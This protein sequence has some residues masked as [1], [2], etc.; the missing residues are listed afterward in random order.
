MF[1]EINEERYWREKRD[2]A[3]TQKLKKLRFRRRQKAALDFEERMFDENKSCRVLFLSIG[4]KPEY[5]DDIALPMMQRYLWRFIRRMREASPR[6]E[7]LYGVLGLQWHLEE[8]G[9]GGGFHA[10][11][12]IFYEPDRSGDVRVCRELGEFWRDEVARGWGGYHNS[13]ADKHRFRSRWGI[14][15]G[16][17]GRNHYEM[18]EALRKL[19]GLYMCKTIQEPLA[20][21]DDDKMWGKVRFARSFR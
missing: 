9:R 7:L 18:R 20:R 8:G 10:H 12:V 19:M 5:R 6:N 1:D 2:S 16:L 14:G 3:D 15:V 17:I 21:D 4:I 11:L 13:N